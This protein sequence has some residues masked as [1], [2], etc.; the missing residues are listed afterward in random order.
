MERVYTHNQSHTHLNKYTD[1]NACAHTHR[2]TYIDAHKG[3]ISMWLDKQT[4]ELIRNY[5]LGEMKGNE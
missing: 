4:S 1:R 5:S 3:I 2:H